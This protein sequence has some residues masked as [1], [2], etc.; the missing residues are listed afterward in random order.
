M[1]ARLFTITTPVAGRVRSGMTQRIV[2]VSTMLIGLILGAALYQALKIA[3]TTAPSITAQPAALD[4]HERHPQLVAPITQN[5]A[6]DQHERHP[7]LFMPVQAARLDQHE[8]HPQLV[9]PITQNTAL[10]QHERHPQLVAPITQ[11][12]AL[13]QHERHPQLVAQ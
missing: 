6:L 2:M 5:A 12:A 4:Q 7:Q 10:D 13:D 8:R 9:A 3:T 1:K 11:N